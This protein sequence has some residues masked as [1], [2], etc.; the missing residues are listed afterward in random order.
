MKRLILIF[1]LC[2]LLLPSAYGRTISHTYSNG[3]TYVGEVKGGKKH[4]QGTYTTAGGPKYV[5]EWKDGKAHGQG[6]YTNHN[7]DTY[8]GEFK[9]D[10]R[11]TRTHYDKNGKV[12][13]TYSK[14]VR[15]PVK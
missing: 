15:T 9:D 10:K 7:G 12:I 14:G 13:A 8:V 5:G 11:W 3:A 4:G 1:V 6:T 2:G